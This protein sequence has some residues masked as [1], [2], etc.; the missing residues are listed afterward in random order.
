MNARTKEC[1][2]FDHVFGPEVQTET[3]FDQQVKQ[4]V[5]TALSGINQTVFAYG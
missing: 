2:A 1:F 4:N 5:H 3:I